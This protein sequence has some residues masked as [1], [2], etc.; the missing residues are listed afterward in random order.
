MAQ[1]NYSV[2]T[3]VTGATQLKPITV[4]NRNNAFQH[5]AV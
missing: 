3:V 1:S 5:F 4:Q 2:T